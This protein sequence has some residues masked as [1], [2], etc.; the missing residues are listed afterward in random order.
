MRPLAFLITLIL[1]G[2]SSLAAAPAAAGSAYSNNF[3]SVPVDSAPDEFLVT[4]GD[5]KVK[6]E[7]ANRY[8][9]LPGAPLDTFG[10][11][12]GPTFKGDASVVA[13]MAGQKQGRK[14]PTF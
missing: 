4:A 3:E 2:A 6:A 5:F 1:P 10:L 12:F 14:F 11:L 13:R 8:L 7:G 9:E